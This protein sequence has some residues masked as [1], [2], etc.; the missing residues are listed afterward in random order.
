MCTNVRFIV[1]SCGRVVIIHYFYTVIYKLGK[2]EVLV[3]D[4][5]IMKVEAVVL[6]PC[7]QG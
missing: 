1:S 2:I 5:R 6:N 7:G 3:R 4:F